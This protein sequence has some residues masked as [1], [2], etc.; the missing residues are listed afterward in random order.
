MRVLQL[1]DSLHAGGA[2]RVAV[3]FANALVSKIDGSFICTTREEGVLK[4]SIDKAVNYLFL[5]KKHTI[6]IGAINRLSKYV[7]L[8]S[9]D[10]VHAHSSSFFLATIIKIFNKRIKIV[11]HDHYGNSEYLDDRKSVILRFCSKYFSQVFCVNEELERW[12]KNYLHV[13]K[14]IYLPNFAVINN[15]KAETELFGVDGKRIVC[16]ANLRPQKNHNLLFNAFKEIIRNHPKWTLHCVGKDFNDSYSIKVRESIKVL[17]LTNNVYFYG[18]KPDISN[19]LSQCEIGVLSSKS[20]GLPLALMEYGIAK[21]AVITTD[22]GDCKK[23]IRNNV[24]GILV[25]KNK[26]IE[27]SASLDALIEDVG[28]RKRFSEN[29]NSFVNEHWS[30]EKIVQRIY[31]FYIEL[32]EEER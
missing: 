29:L 14:A 12:A 6:D 16:L 13:D 15:S 3:N 8:N 25:E 30:E 22:V 11:W 23:V 32:N 21:L 1:I 5:N 27:F 2:E 17:N 26:P 19:I 28:L 18:S 4:N 10:I 20:E 24:N 31:N 9:I 7:K